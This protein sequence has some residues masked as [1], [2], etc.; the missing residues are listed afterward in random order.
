MKN[1]SLLFRLV[2]ILP[3]F[4]S[5]ANSGIQRCLAA[6]AVKAPSFLDRAQPGTF[7]LRVMT[8]NVWV[9]SIFPPN[10]LRHESFGRI[11]KA[12]NPDILC[13]QETDPRRPASKLAGMLDGTLPLKEGLHWQAHYATNMDMVVLSRYPLLRRTQEAVIPRPLPLAPGYH[14]G[15]VMCLVDLP[16]SL[17][18]PDVY[19][20]ATHFISNSEDEASI[21]ARQRH[22]D[23]IVRSLRSLRE[24]DQTNSLPART[25]IV[26]LGDLNVYGSAP[27]DAAHHLATLLTGNIVDEATF[28]PDIK[29]DWDGTYLGEVKPRHNEREKDR[30]T[31]RVDRDRF[32]PDAL[33]RIIYTDSVMR[34]RRS[35]V[36]NTTTMSEEE[37]SKSGLLATD[38]LRGAQPGDFDHMPLVADF[39]VTPQ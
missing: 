16:D 36:L 6:D 37:L 29:P 21:R 18:L 11:V 35:F 9:S 2:L 13:L 10:G 25:P 8:W 24:P 7:D 28:G 1:K 33:D 20:I 22:A 3:L 39:V 27:K 34:V 38:V 31:W 32:P 12:V 30:Y 15:Q 26:I 23:S 19:V 14:M 17:N 5:L 4:I